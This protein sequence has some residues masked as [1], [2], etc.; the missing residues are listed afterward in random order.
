[1]R[2]ILT[3]ENVDDA[4]LVN[5]AR[6]AAQMAG[7][8]WVKA[9]KPDAAYGWDKAHD[10]PWKFGKPVRADGAQRGGLGL[11]GQAQ[12]PATPRRARRER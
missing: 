5:R 6:A 7:A 12:H 8:D 2:G 4:T 11:R 1:M 9:V 10:E 3:T